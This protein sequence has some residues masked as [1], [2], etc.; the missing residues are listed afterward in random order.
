MTDNASGSYGSASSMSSVVAR[1]TVTRHSM[2]DIS[3]FYEP[4]GTSQFLNKCEYYSEE[5]LDAYG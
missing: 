2:D 3:S 1:E 4:D 5:S